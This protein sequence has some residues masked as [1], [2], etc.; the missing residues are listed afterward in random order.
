MSANDRL[1]RRD[2]IPALPVVIEDGVWI[3][4]DSYVCKGVTIGRNS[5]VGA[6]SVVT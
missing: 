5:I 1:A 2:N 4:A 6:K 3:G